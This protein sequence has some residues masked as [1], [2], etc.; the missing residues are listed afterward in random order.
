[1]KPSIAI[2][3]FTRTAQKEAVEK[4]WLGYHQQHKN[5]K[6]ATQLIHQT[7]QFLQQ[8]HLPVFV[9]NE[10]NQ[11]GN[12]FAE[13]FTHAYQTLFNQGFDAVI[14][15]GNDTPGLHQANWNE[16]INKLQQNQ[17]VLGASFNGGAYFLGITKTAFNQQQFLALPWQKE[18]L[19]SELLNFCETNSKQTVFLLKKLHDLNTLSD[20]IKL[21]NEGK[22]KK[23]IAFL[24]A[25]ISSLN[26]FLIVLNQAIKEIYIAQH[27]QLRAPPL[28]FSC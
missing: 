11:V 8:Q 1:M 27:K 4:H 3:F 26:V 7:E 14:S 19:F 21:I 2:L 10:N 17:C 18:T 23:I 15:I 22:I 9:F 20:I 16:A 12:S 13:R 25:L 5:K 28:A 24:Q 6:L